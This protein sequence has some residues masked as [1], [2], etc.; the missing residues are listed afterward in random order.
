M[1]TKESVSTQFNPPLVSRMTPDGRELPDP[2]PMA[3]P[4]GFE[5][6]ESI[7]QLIRRLVTDPSIRADLEAQGEETFDE[8]DDF[9]VEDETFDPS[10]PYEESFDPLHTVSREQEIRS[11]QVKDRSFEEKQAA[12]EVLRKHSEALKAPPVAPVVP[13]KVGA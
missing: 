3:L 9:N 8:A 10:S 13:P 6:P 1:K 7:Q 5:R 12:A 4:V 2:T 11:G